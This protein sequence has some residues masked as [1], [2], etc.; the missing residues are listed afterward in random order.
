MSNEGRKEPLIVLLSKK[1]NESLRLKAIANI[2]I[3]DS[4]VVQW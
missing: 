2:K 4:Q 3:M 1:A